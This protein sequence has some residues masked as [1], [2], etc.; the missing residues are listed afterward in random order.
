MALNFT[1]SSAAVALLVWLIYFREAQQAAFSLGFLPA[2]NAGLNGMSALFLIRGMLAIHK[3]RRELH[4]A[5]MKLAMVF[6]A[7]FLVSYILYHTFHGD[8]LFQGQGFIRPVYFFI[9]ISH[10]VLSIAVLP[11]VFTSFFFA[12][13]GNF[14]AHKKISRFTFPLWFYVSVTGVAIFVL[15]KIHS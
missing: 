11:M 13:R 3:G 10:I 1:V 12:L 6:S 9:L 2:V 5:C 4:E 15:L 7:L 14:P 8:T